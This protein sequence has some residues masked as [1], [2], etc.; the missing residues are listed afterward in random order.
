MN[1]V[2]TALFFE[3]GAYRF[4]E[5]HCGV[6]SFIRCSLGAVK[7]GNRQL[8]RVV[9][10]I[11]RDVFSIID[12]EINGK[13]MRTVLFQYPEKLIANAG[14]GE[15]VIKLIGKSGATVTGCQPLLK[16]DKFP[17]RQADILSR[18]VL[19]QPRV[20]FF[21]NDHLISGH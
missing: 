20:A 11:M 5:F 7:Q 16:D 13:N 17:S 18:S 1:T 4:R 3:N 9:G 15:P 8:V 6:F 21:W 10:T 19:E 2:Q 12:V 14:G